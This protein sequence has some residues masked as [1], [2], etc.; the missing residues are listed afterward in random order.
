MRNEEPGVLESVR[1]ECV[2]EHCPCL[3]WLRALEGRRKTCARTP[4]K[5]AS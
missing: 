1:E 5:S 4:P 3:G 2:R